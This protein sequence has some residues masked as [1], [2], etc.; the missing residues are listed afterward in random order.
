MFLCSSFKNKKRPE[1]SQF[2]NC[3]RSVFW[4]SWEEWLRFR[5]L[6]L[7]PKTD[8][9]RYFIHNYFVIITFYLIY[10]FIF[11]I[12]SISFI[13]HR[14]QKIWSFTDNMFMW[15]YGFFKISLPVVSPIFHFN[16]IDYSNSHRI[17]YE[18]SQC[19]YSAHLS[20]DV[21]QFNHELT[22]NRVDDRTGPSITSC[23]ILWF[24]RNNSL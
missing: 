20:W 9:I 1:T 13:F 5:G 15:Y 14:F 17:F 19:V 11:L 12:H 7:C 6:Y 8:Y 24:I 23:T 22:V 4:E 2:E 3:K 21:E 18:K 10:W 16:R